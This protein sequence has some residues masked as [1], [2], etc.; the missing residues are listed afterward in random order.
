MQGF[1]VGDF[2]G[3]RADLCGNVQRLLAFGGI[4]LHQSRDFS[5]ISINSRLTSAR[6]LHRRSMLD[7]RPSSRRRYRQYRDSINTDQTWSTRSVESGDG[8]AKDKAKDKLKRSRSFWRLFASFWGFTKAHRSWLYMG[9]AALTLVACVGLLIPASTKVALDY[10]IA[11]TPGP[12]GIPVEVREWLRIPED[13]VGMLWYLGMF[14]VG[15]AV[16]GAVLGTVGRWQFTRVTKRI[17]VDM[18]RKA[19]SHAAKLP[20]HRIQHYKSGG[21][22]S[23]LREDGGLAGD[24]LFSMI[25]NPWRA[26]VQLVGTLSILA[27]VDWRMLIGAFVLI[28]VVWMTHKTW[29]SK[30]RPFYRDQKSVR[31][32]IDATTTEAFGGMRVV[33]GFGRERAESGRF[34][35]SQH[36]LARIEILTWWW[37]RL[38]E[39]IWTILIPAASAGV[40]IY[41]GSQVLKG[42]LTIGDLM[43]FSTYLLMLLGPIET[44]TSTASQIQTNL[45][46][47]DRLLDLL[48]EE[49]EF[50]GR[51]GGAKVSKA[52]TRGAIRIEDVSFGYPQ[53]KRPVAGAPMRDDQVT[54]STIIGDP[55][56]RNIS[57]DVKAGET[58]AFVGPSGSGKTTLCNLIAR[59][60]DPTSG[61][62]RL[63]GVNLRDIDIR[64]FRSLLGIV[65][66]DVFLFDGTVAEN[67]VYA[68]RSASAAQ[69]MEAARA[70]NALGFIQD[71]DNGF[72]TFIGERGVRLSGGQ[73]QRIAIARAILADPKI[74]ILDEATSNLDSES[75]A[76]IQSS[77]MSLMRGRTCFV[78]AHRLSTIRHADRI[79]VLEDGRICEVGTHDQLLAQSGR[80]ADLVKIQTMGPLAPRVPSTPTQPDPY[81]TGPT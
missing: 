74:L 3:D 1:F 81:A 68:N 2:V 39:I 50:G 43:M 57:L 55:V 47:L 73:K 76:L 11:D 21:M 46:A 16:F 72:G 35:S 79:V 65:E 52:T 37:S 53:V 20:L 40:L 42:R 44:L 71:L 15:V 4:K 54:G 58:I 51:R 63:D 14:M 23:L 31:Q 67:I 59:F 27:F 34:V 41:G 36:Y 48:N 38:L 5:W 18:R 49:E 61:V 64:S 33:R 60:Y 66:Q 8:K 75:E 17:Q 32:G 26:I 22:S 6:I 62:I 29:I 10:V 19:F 24:L 45:A 9:L 77:L 69:I 13:R 80:Y 7:K 28:P 30:I 78:I 56:L 12:Q 25:Y 70:A